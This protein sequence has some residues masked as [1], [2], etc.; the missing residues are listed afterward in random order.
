MMRVFFLCS[1]IRGMLYGGADSVFGN[2]PQ[3]LRFMAVID[4][5][6]AIERLQ[7]SLGVVC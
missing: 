5:E 6:N 2:T 1:P 3:V 7:D 4:P